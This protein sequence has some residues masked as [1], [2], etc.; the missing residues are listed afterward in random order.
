MPGNRV[1]LLF[2]SNY[3]NYTV[4]GLLCVS[5]TG[6]AKGHLLAD[7]RE[8]PGAIAFCSV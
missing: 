3:E 7:F 5:Y 4:F 6:F 8:G 1:V 2:L